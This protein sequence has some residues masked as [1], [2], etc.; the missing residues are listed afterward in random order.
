MINTIN[1]LERKLSPFIFNLIVSELAS[2]HVNSYKDLMNKNTSIW[3]GL[4]LV[5]VNFAYSLLFFR[6]FSVF[7]T[8]TDSDTIIY[9]ANNKT[10]AETDRI[11]ELIGSSGSKVLVITNV[12]GDFNINDIKVSFRY[13]PSYCFVLI[14]LLFQL[15]IIILCKRLSVREL[16]CVSLAFKNIGLYY[17]WMQVVL[18]PDAERVV[19][20]F[21]ATTEGHVLN[22]VASESNINVFTYSWGSNIAALEQL[23]TI[24]DWVLLKSQCEIGKYKRGNDVVVGDLGLKPVIV[25]STIIDVCLIDTCFSNKFRLE[26]KLIMY[27][28][29]INWL[30]LS[31]IDKLHIIFHPGSEEVENTLESLSGLGVE[32]TSS[33]GNLRDVIS[34]SGLVLNVVSTSL[35]DVIVSK[36]PCVNF[37][38]YYFEKFL[39]ESSLEH[40][41]EFSS[42]LDIRDMSELKP[43]SNLDDF[44]V[45]C[46]NEQRYNGFMSRYAC[47]QERLEHLK[48]LFCVSKP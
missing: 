24:Q 5:A 40:F 8:K 39:P 26:E 46:F 45:T 19:N 30:T 4:I 17:K 33:T 6:R 20:F 48:E 31:K 21:S 37:A 35:R 11:K 13:F 16:V 23:Y 9:S 38:P 7:Y 14:S 43:F 18:R 15:L 12:D 44:K 32:I 25:E 3:S 27:H 47:T 42:G 34:M 36:I 10:I 1:N 2:S 28:S 29:I 41:L 22:Y